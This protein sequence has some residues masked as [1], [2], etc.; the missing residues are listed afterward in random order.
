[1]NLFCLCFKCSFFPRRFISFTHWLSS[2]IYF[3]HAPIFYL[4]LNT[5]LNSKYINFNKH[6]IVGNLNTKYF[7]SS[8]TY[9]KCLMEIGLLWSERVAAGR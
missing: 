3:F 2:F 4:F 7:H 1:M 9:I 8:Y 6:K 5:K